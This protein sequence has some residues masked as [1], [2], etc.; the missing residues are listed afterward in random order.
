MKTSI[1][2]TVE[3]A[4]RRWDT[5]PRSGWNEF[6]AARARLFASLAAQSDEFRA[7]M[8]GGRAVNRDHGSWSN[9]GGA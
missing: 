7:G 9:G 1:Q 4:E 6:Q 2:P 5:Q 8:A 3:Q